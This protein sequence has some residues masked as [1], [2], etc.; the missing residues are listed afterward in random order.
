M[1]QPFGFCLSFLAVLLLGLP[2]AGWAAGEKAGGAPAPHASPASL[3]K[4]EALIV[5][6]KPGYLFLVWD[7]FSQREL[8]DP[9]QPASGKN[10][11]RYAAYV[12]YAYGFEKYPEYPE[13]RVRLLAFKGR[14]E[15]GGPRWDLAEEWHQ[16]TFSAAKFK[17]RKNFKPEAVWSLDEKTLR[18]MLKDPNP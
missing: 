9:T 12:A 18:S 7:V 8:F 15:Y 1:R 5:T 2:A 17:V 16:F 11:L 4:P 14:D 10:A 13:A 3:V 6:K